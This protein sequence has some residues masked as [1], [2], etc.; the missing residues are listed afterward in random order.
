MSVRTTDELVEEIIEVDSTISLTPF[1]AVANELVTEL[2]TDSDY[3][4]SRLLLI[5]TWLAAHFYAIRDP[6]IESEKAGSVS[7]KRAIK[8]GLNLQQTTY[9]Q[10]AML[11][12]T[13]GN[14]A[15]LNKGM[16]TGKRTP[17]VTWAGQYED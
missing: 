11:L 9:G 5:E 1:I 16:D 14:L 10:Q 15:A 7:E 2:C 6:R 12:D 4:S 17:S 13:S 8:I 3:S